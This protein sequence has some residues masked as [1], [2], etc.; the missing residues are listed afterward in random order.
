MN[1]HLENPVG[2]WAQVEVSTH[3]LDDPRV[4]SGLALPGRV[5]AYPSDNILS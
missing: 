5:L 3:G 4:I 1:E 2:G